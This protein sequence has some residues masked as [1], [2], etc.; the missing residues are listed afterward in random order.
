MFVCCMATIQLTHCYP[1]ASTSGNWFWNIVRDILHDPTDEQEKCQAPKPILLDTGSINWPYPWSPHIVPLQILSVG[2]LVMI[3][4]PGEFSTMSGRWLRG[5]VS[6]V[7]V[8]WLHSNTH[9]QLHSATLTQVLADNG[10]NDSVP[11]IAG[12]SNTYSDYITTYYEYQVQ[13]MSLCT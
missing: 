6:K 5:N 4:V 8:V 13:H 10:F 2:Q 1:T 3:A 12:L 9:Q 7:S 11:V